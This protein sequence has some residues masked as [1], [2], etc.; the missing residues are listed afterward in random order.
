MAFS[1]KG[2]AFFRGKMR[3]L[4]KKCNPKW[5]FREKGLL[6]SRSRAKTSAKN[7]TLN[8]VFEKKG[9]FFRG[10]GRKS[11]KKGNPHSRFREKGLLFAT[12]PL[13]LPACRRSSSPFP[14][15]MI[16]SC[17]RKGR[18]APLWPV[19]SPMLRGG[20]AVKG[21]NHARGRRACP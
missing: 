10:A 20:G 17:R 15:P 1:G 12:L 16:L 18:G 13:F 4:A 19:V 2:V 8:A 9:C 11:L 3:P 14:R 7:A 21:D 6:F 5:R